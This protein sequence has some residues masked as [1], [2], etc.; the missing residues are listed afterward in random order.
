[1]GNNEY[2][3]SSKAEQIKQESIRKIVLTYKKD[4]LAIHLKGL[5]L[6]MGDIKINYI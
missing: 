2:R 6:N 4:T 5:A 1:M 3:K